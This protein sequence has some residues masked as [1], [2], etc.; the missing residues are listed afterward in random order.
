MYYLKSRFYNP[1]LR[2]FMI[3]D[4]I[5]Y[6]DINNVGCINL[7]AYCNNNPV[8][9]VDTDGR[10]ILLIIGGLLVSGIITGFGAAAGKADDESFWGA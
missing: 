6:L 3:P 1:T 2:R 4:N 9:Y 10:G 7:Y 5:N 8:M